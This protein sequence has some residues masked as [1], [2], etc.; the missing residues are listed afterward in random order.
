M[1]KSQK[2]FLYI[3]RSISLIFC[4]PHAIPFFP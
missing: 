1:A 3:Y 2:M 4:N